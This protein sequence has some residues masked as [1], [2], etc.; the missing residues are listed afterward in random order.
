MT[1]AHP[2]R[3]AL[4]R[5]HEE[6]LR[7]NAELEKRNAELEKRN[8]ELEERLASVHVDVTELKLAEQA[9][10]DRETLLQV[11][12]DNAPMLIYAKDLEGRYTLASRHAAKAMGLSTDA[13]VGKSDFELFPREVAELIV[14]KDRELL[15]TQQPL[16]YEESVLEG[17]TRVDLLTTKF[18]LFDAEGKLYGLC[19]IST[20]ITELRKAQKEQRELQEEMLRVQET[21]LRALSTPLIPIAKGVLVMPLIGDVDRGRAR[22]VLETLLHGVARE[23]ARI[24]ILDVTGIQS[25]GPEVADGLV[26]A[27][28]AVGLL[29]AQVVLT[30]VQPA[31]AQ[32]LA[33]LGTSLS[34]LVIRGTLESGI[35]YAMRAR[36]R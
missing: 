22:H 25:A 13:S 12:V 34:N 20:N 29:G 8:A 24:A 33:D 2:D 31:M 11:I 9:A 19:G 16:S 28:Q 35:A 36:G 7:R 3:E 15:E 4:Q 27:A 1:I 17:E 18:P 26:Q 23:R 14:T 6:I 10:R 5:E 32:A 21:V 30:G